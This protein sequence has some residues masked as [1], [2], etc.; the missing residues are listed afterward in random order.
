M[1]RPSLDFLGMLAVTWTGLISMK[2]KDETN[3]LIQP[4]QWRPVHRLSTWESLSE[5]NNQ[6]V[7]APKFPL[8][9]GQEVGVNLCCSYTSPRSTKTGATHGG[10][11]SR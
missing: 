10:A 6:D 8:Y 11:S 7:Q 9:P 1:R 4:G 5:I 2:N 3:R